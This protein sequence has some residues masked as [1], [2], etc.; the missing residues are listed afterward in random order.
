[1]AMIYDSAEVRRA[2]RTVRSSMDRITSSAQPKVKSIRSQLS[3]N[4]EGA[5][6]D[7]L[8]K[9]LYE[10]DADIAKIV[11]ALN[12]LNRT[13]VRFADEIDAADARIKAALKALK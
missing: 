3:E 6:A 11:S 9:R 10:L 5:T 1:M 8:N 7:A 4:M 2:A 12:A 13:L